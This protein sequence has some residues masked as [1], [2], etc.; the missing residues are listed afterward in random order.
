MAIPANFYWYR[1]IRCINPYEV[2]IKD[3][4]EVWKFALKLSD[5]MTEELDG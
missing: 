2:Q 5:Q 1:S 4:I 3:V